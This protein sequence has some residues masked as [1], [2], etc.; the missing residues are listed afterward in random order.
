MTKKTFLSST[1]SHVAAYPRTTD[2]TDIDYVVN[3]DVP[4]SI[5]EYIHRI[6]RTG[7]AGK[8][9]TSVTFLS[10]VSSDER[11]RLNEVEISTLVTR[12]LASSISSGGGLY[13]SATVTTLWSVF[14]VII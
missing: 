5:T 9:G 3:Y 8:S 12:A 2:V 13:L 11:A 6:G 14:T 1:P 10:E 4:T 7:R